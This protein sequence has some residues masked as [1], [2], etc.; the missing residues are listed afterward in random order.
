MVLHILSSLFGSGNAIM[1]DGNL[2]DVFAPGLGCL[3]KVIVL[4]PVLV[5][6]AAVRVLAADLSKTELTDAVD[7]IKGR[8][9][10]LV[11]EFSC[12]V[13]VCLVPLPNCL[14]AR[15]DVLS[16]RANG[17]GESHFSFVDVDV[18]GFLW[19]AAYDSKDTCFGAVDHTFDSLLEL[20]DK[21][22]TNALNL[23]LLLMFRDLVNTFLEV[24]ASFVDGLGAHLFP[25]L[26]ILQEQL[27][28]FD[29]RGR[30]SCD[31]ACRG[32][33][34]GSLRY[35]RRDARGG[36]RCSGRGNGNA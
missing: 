34:L 13:G 23:T 4:G 36:D 14:G 28:G 2:L 16:G 8:L 6:Q 31:A 15:L 1:V 3:L 26:Q 25:A 18:G 11:D 17:D 19:E 32:G 22:V 21:R 9:E 7:G 27:A 35:G 24:L 20:D 10:S 29:R 12:L 30:L 5:S 33:S